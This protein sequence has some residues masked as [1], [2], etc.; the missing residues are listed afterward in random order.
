MVDDMSRAA[1]V[2]TLSKRPRRTAA[3]QADMNIHAAYTYGED[4]QDSGRES[5]GIYSYGASDMSDN[6]SFRRSQSSRS[7]L[8]S[9]PMTSMSI[10]PAKL[11][12]QG[13][14]ET[15]PAELARLGD[16]SSVVR[17]VPVF[18]EDM[19]AKIRQNH[20]GSTCPDTI[21]SLD[22]SLNSAFKKTS[23]DYPSHLMVQGGRK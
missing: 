6:R 9:P 22:S 20:D 11:Q 4:D 17:N 15:W 12:R 18:D 1:A 7:M 14:A 5:S 3:K 19:Y 21:A 2:D 10:L 8:P 13:S 23:K 16:N